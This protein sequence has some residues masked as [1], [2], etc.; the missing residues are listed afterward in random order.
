MIRQLQGRITVA[1]VEKG[2]TIVMMENQNQSLRSAWILIS[3]LYHWDEIKE[4][5]GKFG[6]DL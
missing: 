6:R 1:I 3:R 5:G 2:E 4:T